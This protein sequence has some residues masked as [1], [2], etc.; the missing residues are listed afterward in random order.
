MSRHPWRAGASCPHCGSEWLETG[1]VGGTCPR[2]GFVPRNEIE[3][4]RVTPVTER[5]RDGQESHFR[6]LMRLDKPMGVERHCNPDRTVMLAAL[7]VVLGLP[8]AP[9]GWLKELGR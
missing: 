4:I 8:S 9:P 6:R 7:R 1:P 3:R 2:H 5:L